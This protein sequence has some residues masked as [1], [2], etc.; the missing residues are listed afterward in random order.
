[1]GMNSMHFYKHNPT[2]TRI[3]RLMLHEMN[4]IT[5][6]YANHWRS[7]HPIKKGTTCV[8]KNILKV[9]MNYSDKYGKMPFNMNQLQLRSD[10]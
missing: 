6:A 7:N 8:L 3:Y 5:I 9:E 10:W 2:Y 1:M 4:Q